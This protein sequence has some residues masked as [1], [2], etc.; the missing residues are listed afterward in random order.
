LGP[1]ISSAD[2][3]TLGNILTFGLGLD[4]QKIASTNTTLFFHTA[5][6]Y[7]D[8]NNQVDDYQI[9]SSAPESGL[10][11]TGKVGFSEA[12]YAKGSMLSSTGYSI[13]L[14]T[15]YDFSSAVNIGA[16]FNYG[17]EYWFSATQGAEDMYNKLATRGYVGEVY[18]VWK[19]HKNIFSKLGFMLSHENYTGSGWHFGEPVKKDADQTISY[20]TI[21]AK[22]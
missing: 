2:A 3:H 11:A 9:L 6:S 13:Y 17:S 1:D 4:I 16:E 20:L 21:E 12:D 14:G 5:L 19:F 8:G 18:G 15:K 10:T 22:F 7:P